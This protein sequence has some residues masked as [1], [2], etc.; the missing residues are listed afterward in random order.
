M[1][2]GATY[3]ALGETDAR[4]LGISVAPGDFRYKAN[5]ANGSTAAALA[6]IGRLRIGTAELRDVEAMV[7]KGDLDQVLLGM[8]F[9]G[10]LRSV[11]MRDGVLELT[12]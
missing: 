8:S 1:D 3:V 11:G 10:R 9:L 4:R 2:T 7:L 12:P 6:R 5:T